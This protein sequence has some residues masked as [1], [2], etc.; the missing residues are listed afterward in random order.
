MQLAEHL[1]AVEHWEPTVRAVVGWDAGAARRR[2]QSSGSG[3]LAGWAIGV[4]DILDLDGTPT[5]C[6]VEFLPPAPKTASARIV[7]QLQEQGAYALAKT[8]T[9]CFAYLDPGPT[10]NPWNPQHTPGGS[11]MGSAAAVATGMVRAAIGTQTVGSVCRPASFCGVV[12]FKPSYGAISTEGCFALVPTFDTIGFF[13]RTV[14]DMTTLWHAVARRAAPAEEP[15]GPLVVGIVED[16]RCKPFDAEMI[17]ALRF[18][19]DRLH[20]CG[21]ATREVT[22]PAELAA[23]YDNNRVIFEV[24]AARAHAELWARHRDAYPPKLKAVLESAAGGDSGERYAAA[25]AARADAQERFAALFGGIDVVLA[26]A[27]P[28]AAPRDLTVTGDPRANLLFTHVRAP[29]VSLPA[30]LGRDGLPLGLQCAAPAG[31]DTVVLAAARAIQDALG[32]DAA[33]PEPRPGD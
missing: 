25:C 14:Q 2:A 26:P 32:F 15:T 20:A 29:V 18:A 7:D 1:R 28:G 8:V 6:G 16:L 4:K 11:S 23:V 9:T 3:P 24:E 10:R 21:I 5:A 13:T 31:S 30:R 17:G 27:A 33:P 22:L 12:G 19:R